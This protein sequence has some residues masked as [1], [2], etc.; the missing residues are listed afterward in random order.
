LDPESDVGEVLL[1][2]KFLTQPQKSVAA[3]EKSLDQLMQLAI[4]VYYNQ[5][6]TKKREKDKNTMT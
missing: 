5:D 1:K 6:V 4:F 3:W 2:D